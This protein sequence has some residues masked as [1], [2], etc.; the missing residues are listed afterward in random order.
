MKIWIALLLI[1]L[2]LCTAC[3]STAAP[4]TPSTDTTQAPPT[5]PEELSATPVVDNTLPD[6]SWAGYWELIRVDS[7][8]PDVRLTEEEITAAR[9]QGLPM[10]LE[11]LEDGTGVFCFDELT[12]I[13][14]DGTTVT[15][16]GDETFSYSV[17]ENRLVIDMREL[18]CVFVQGE[19]PGS[20]NS[21]MEEAGFVDY[22]KEWEPYPYTTLCADDENKT[23]TGEA[24]VI[25][26]EIFPSAQGYPEKAGYEWRVVTIEVRF[27]D[28]N[29]QMYGASPFH[30]FED[31]YCVQLHDD[32]LTEQAPDAGYACYT[33]TRMFCGEEVETSLR[34]RDSW[35]SWRKDA[36]GNDE[37]F[38]NVEF[39]FHVPQGYDGAVAGLE[40]G[41]YLCPEGSYI[42]DCDPAYF[43]LFRLK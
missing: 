1:P 15:V 22:M 31:Y 4:E 27:F 17:A 34:V 37:C 2:L 16:V 38:Y 20:C 26:Y 30:R 29:V 10:Y 12:A 5:I 21:E 13:L 43:L 11:L 39:A 9:K 6:L 40:N 23:T 35:S 18:T 19:K 24:T 32:T 28:E 25:A 42:T 14:W 36:N 7:D 8:N 3:G 41:S 33:T